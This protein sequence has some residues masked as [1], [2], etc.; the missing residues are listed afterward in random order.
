MT[1]EPERG[2]IELVDKQINCAHEVVLPDPVLQPLRKKRRLIAADTLDET[3][4]EN[5]PNRE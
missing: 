4:H 2:Q 3:R 5:P 1:L